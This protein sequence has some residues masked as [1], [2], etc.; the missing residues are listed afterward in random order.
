VRAVII[1]T[2][3]SKT[4]FVYTLASASTALSDAA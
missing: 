4:Q 3:V 2:E 1:G